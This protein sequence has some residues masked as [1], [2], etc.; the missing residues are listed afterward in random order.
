M[1][2]LSRLRN[3]YAAGQ[4]STATLESRVS[5]ALSGDPD[6]AVWDLPRR[7]QSRRG[8]PRVLVVDGGDV[9]LERC[10]RIG[11]SA[12]C[13]LVLPDDSVSRRH[14]EIALRGGVCVVRDLGSCNGT[15]VNGRAVTRARLR[16]GDEL[17][18]GETVLRLT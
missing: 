18:L 16:R 7:W 9:A 5:L 11:R 4:V 12:S 10:L 3:A 14:A 2:A 15:Y 8:A 6:G 13:D 17:M 1:R